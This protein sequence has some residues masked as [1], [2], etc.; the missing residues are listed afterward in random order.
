MALASKNTCPVYKTKTNGALSVII[1]IA[2]VGKRMKTR[3]PKAL[4]RIDDETVLEKQV[5]IIKEV[6]PKADIIVVAGFQHKK[7]RNKTWGNLP[8]RI[9][10]NNEYEETNVCHGVS[11][12]L[13]ASL[14]GPLMI[15]HGDLIFN[16][17]AINGLARES[18]LLIDAN[19][20]MRRDEIGIGHQ[21]GFVTSLS[22]ALDSKWGQVAFFTGKEL[23]LF[24]KAVRNNEQWF[25]H[26]AINYVINRGGKFNAYINKKANI[27]EIDRYSD[28]KQ[29]KNEVENE[30]IS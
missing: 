8:I 29:Y 1:P 4:L 23:E 30:N 21:D 10:Y 11:I 5:N 15:I 7:V 16:K 13:D 18:S 9:V 20:D 25:L 3:G 2:G 22:Y 19:G 17:Y 28:F 12:G 6:Y 26:E 14:P 24:I 27:F